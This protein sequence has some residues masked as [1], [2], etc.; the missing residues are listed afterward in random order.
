MAI[1]NMRKNFEV[2]GIVLAL[3]MSV[4]AIIGGIM[5]GFRTESVWNGLVA[6]GACLL[7]VGAFF[8]GTMVYNNGNNECGISKIMYITTA[9]GAW[10]LAISAIVRTVPLLANWASIYDAIEVPTNWSL[11]IGGVLFA[12]PLVIAALCGF[13]KALPDML[14]ALVRT[15]DE[16]KILTGIITGSA[17]A[18]GVF[19]DWAA[20]IG[21]AIFFILECVFI[22]AWKKVEQEDSKVPMRILLTSFILF[23]AGPMTNILIEMFGLNEVPF[24]NSISMYLAYSA[25]VILALLVVGCLLYGMARLWCKIV[26]WARY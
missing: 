11:G 13:I 5:T 1:K 2:F 21:F 6:G 25:G 3:A 18:I 19:F 26:S 4:F 8:I 9:V 17:L 20:G 14:K 7:G 10:V 16:H 22:T 24:M 23:L 12:G 15:I